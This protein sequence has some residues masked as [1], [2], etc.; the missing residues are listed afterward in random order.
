MR[1]IRYDLQERIDLVR[2]QIRAEQAQ[3]EVRI[4]QL[5]KEQS[6]RLDDLRAQLQAV[7]R[8]REIATWQHNVRMAVARA[9]AV[10]ATVEISAHDFLKHND[11]SGPVHADGLPTAEQVPPMSDATV[12]G[13]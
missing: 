12:S 8:L 6:P 7:T 5:R 11:L 1:D 13:L 10:A 4:A 3:F 2:Q 9:L